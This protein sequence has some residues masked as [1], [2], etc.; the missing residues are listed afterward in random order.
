MVPSRSN[1]EMAE[2]YLGRWT[3]VCN[4][5]SYGLGEIWRG[6]RIYFM[7][8]QEGAKMLREPKVQKRSA[9]GMRKLHS[10]ETSELEVIAGPLAPAGKW[11]RQPKNQT[12]PVVNSLGIS[13]IC[14][15]IPRIATPH[16][17]WVR[18]QRTA[19]H[20]ALRL[21]S[22]L[23]WVPGIQKPWWEGSERPLEGGSPERSLTN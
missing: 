1:S 15:E 8:W 13:T 10:T 9:F 12:G 7:S 6:T 18:T 23:P 2:R 20:T 4:P 14:P 5:V 19:L 17:K 22:L 16:G 11:K 3:C 21:F